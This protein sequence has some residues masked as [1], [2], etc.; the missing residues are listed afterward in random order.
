MYAAK[1]SLLAVA[2]RSGAKTWIEHAGR[3]LHADVQPIVRR[4]SYGRHD[5]DYRR[6][7]T[8][9]EAAFA[10]NFSSSAGF[11]TADYE[12]ADLLSATNLKT[13]YYFTVT[14]M[15]DP[16]TVARA[17]EDLRRTDAEILIVPPLNMNSLCSS[18]RDEQRELARWLLYPYRVSRKHESCRMYDPYLAYVLENYH[19]VGDFPDLF[20]KNS[21]RDTGQIE[22]RAN[23]R[24]PR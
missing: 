18:E 8:R 19:P 13:H 4:L 1:T 5:F 15:F 21:I 6:A 24:P 16:E 22:L 14:N 17:L 23:G 12:L 11:L 2:D 3:I 10:S 7:G 9:S 20:V